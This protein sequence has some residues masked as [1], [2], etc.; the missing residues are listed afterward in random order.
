MTTQQ[1]FEELLSNVPNATG[2]AY[3]AFAAAPDVELRAFV[4]GGTRVP[5]VSIRVPI[6]SVP[7]GLNFPRVRGATISARAN[8]PSDAGHVT[9]E[10][11]ASEAAFTTVFVQLSSRLIEEI[12]ETDSAR[13]AL[14]TLAG[15]LVAWA[16]FFDARDRDGLGRSAQ[17]GLIGELLCLERLCRLVEPAQAVR[18]WTGPKGSTFDFQSVAGAIE[19][20]LSTSSAPERFRISSERQ[21]DESAVRELLL[22]TISVQEGPAAA[23]RLVDVVAR[24]RTILAAS[25]PGSLVEYEDLLLQSGYLDSDEARYEVRVTVKNFDF[26]AVRAGFPRILP[27]ELRKG[28]FAV[29]Y[30]ISREAIA[31]FFVPETVAGDLIRAIE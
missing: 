6:E 29:S 25:A 13:S 4:T 22:C 3:R 15:R 19:V 17:L 8:Q 24:V 30:D 21:L 20:K 18:A 28:V 14:N 11:V 10:L 7:N 31:P 26:A 1:I 5:G 16:R 12:Q 9:F 23:A 2:V 27:D